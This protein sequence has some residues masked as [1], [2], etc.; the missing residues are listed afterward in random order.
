MRH[1]RNG[2]FL[3]GAVKNASLTGNE[4]SYIGSSAMAAWGYTGDCLN[5]NCSLRL[6]V[7]SKRKAFQAQTFFMD[8]SVEYCSTEFTARR[9]P[10]VSNQ[11]T[12]EGHF[13]GAGRARH[14]SATWDSGILADNIYAH[15]AAS[16]P[17]GKAD[18]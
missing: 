1:L 5:E 14:A 13:D 15:T 16:G 10:R 2:I 18:Q 7:A 3:D 17:A 9:S 11:D 8:S 4:F 6:G 12:A